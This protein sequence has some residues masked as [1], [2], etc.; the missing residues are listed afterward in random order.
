MRRL[1]RFLLP[2]LCT[3]SL[4]LCLGAGVMWAR[5]FWWSDGVLVHR[6]A[7][8]SVGPG[9]RTSRFMNHSTLRLPETSGT[10]GR[11]A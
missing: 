7:A 11:Q 5:S 4:L 1:A 9:S 3:L 8:S 6:R 10:I 2:A